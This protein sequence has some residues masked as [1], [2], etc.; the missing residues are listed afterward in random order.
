MPDAHILILGGTAEARQLAA[1]LTGRAG[2]AVTTSLAGRV[3]HPRLPPG[4]VRIGG[5][6]GADGLAGWL[7]E[8]AVDAV[9]D[10]THPFATTISAHAARAA[11][12]TGV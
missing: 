4:G 2:T 7:R 10:A 12:A 6:G 3:A 11:A 9:V 8:H 5:F 1:E